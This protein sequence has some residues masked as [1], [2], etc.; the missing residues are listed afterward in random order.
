[1]SGSDSM[2]EKALPISSIATRAPV[3][4]APASK[5]ALTRSRSSASRSLVSE[6]AM[7]RP[8]GR[9]GMML[10]AE[11]PS[12]T[13]P[14][15]RS[16]GRNCW[17]KRPIAT[18][19]MVSASS[20]LIADPGRGRGV[21]LLA[22]EGDVEVVDRETERVE[23]FGGEGVHHHRG[24]HVIE[25]AGVDEVDLAAAAF[26]GRRAEQGDRDV[27]LVGDG[28]QADGGAQRRRGDD[29][30]AA[31]VTDVGERV[32]L[33]AVHDV[34]VAA[35]PWWRERRWADRRCRARR[36]KPAPSANVGDGAGAFELLVPEF[37]VRVDEVA[38]C[39][40]LVAVALDGAGGDFARAHSTT[41]TVSPALTESPAVDVDRHDDAGLLGVHRV[42]HLH[43]LE[44][45]DRVAGLDLLSDLDV[46]LDDRPLHRDDDVGRAAAQHAGVV[47]ATRF[48][49]G[50]LGRGAVR[51][52][53]PAPTA[54]R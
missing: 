47:L 8:T 30:V 16:P 24:V 37:G 41:T 21:R 35:R 5:Q 39:D 2:C 25:V 23:S 18:W 10:A 1:M 43:R 6:R 36:R 28:A 4:R 52:R 42:L 48:A 45:N 49:R 31:G 14:C 13:T 15:T 29:V 9:L 46:H 11:P 54:R 34:Q 3:A 32:E 51:R 53:T 12:S 22:L 17:R 26:L 50:A 44:D 33:G 19:E 40:Q 7:N 38:E 20:A 27:Q